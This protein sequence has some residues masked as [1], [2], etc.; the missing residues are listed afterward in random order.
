MNKLKHSS[1]LVSTIR[2]VI[3]A[4]KYKVQPYT[5]G[6]RIILS[7]END[8][9]ED[10]YAA[11]VNKGVA[12]EH[13]KDWYMI[14]DCLNNINK[15]I[16]DYGSFSKTINAILKDKLGYRPCYTNYST[17]GSVNLKVDINANSKER[18]IELAEA[19]IAE[20][21]NKCEGL[22]VTINGMFLSMGGRHECSIN[23]PNCCGKSDFQRRKDF[24]AKYGM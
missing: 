14:K 24:L 9:N 15:D 6:T 12:Y 10:L 19:A 16:K 17:G 3:G 18:A 21:N 5:Y 11:L 4:A 13:Q 2:E 20:I 1:E 22:N 7:G 23:I 8:N